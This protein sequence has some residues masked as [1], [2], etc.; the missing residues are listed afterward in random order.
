MN[1]IIVN[2]RGLNVRSGPTLSSTRLRRLN[3]GDL[4]PIET[5]IIN[6]GDQWGKLAGDDPQARPEY[7]A[8]RLRGIVYAA[9]AQDNAPAR[10]WMSAMDAWARRCGYSG[11]APGDE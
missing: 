8:I 9:P 10:A 6:N 5:T 3:V 11:P 7:I 1:Y 4:V 2:P